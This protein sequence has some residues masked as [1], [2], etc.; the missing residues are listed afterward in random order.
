ML[1]K[2]LAART[3]GCYSTFAA[4]DRMCAAVLRSIC[5]SPKSNGMDVN[6][7]HPANAGALRH[8]ERRGRG[9][10]APASRLWDDPGAGRP[11]G[12]WVVHPATGVL[13]AFAQ[14]TGPYA[15]RLPPR[16]LA[17]G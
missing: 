4:L 7:T 6:F 1:S 9:G 15:L 13:F 8:L 12:A 14:G 5:C 2:K 17:A 11:P 16:E 10:R 3:P